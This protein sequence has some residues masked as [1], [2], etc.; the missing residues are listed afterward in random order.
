MMAEASPIHPGQ[1]LLPPVLPSRALL[2]VVVTTISYLPALT[3]F[4]H[5]DDFSIIYSSRDFRPTSLHLGADGAIRPFYRPLVFASMHLDRRLWGL[6]PAGF[7]LTNFMI[8]L[9]YVASVYLLAWWLPSIRTSTQTRRRFAALCACGFALHP[10]ATESVSWVAGR[11]GSQ[12]AFFAF[13]GAAAHAGLLRAGRAP[14]TPIAALAYPLAAGSKESVILFPFAVAAITVVIVRDEKLPARIAYHAYGSCL[15]WFGIAAG[16]LFLRSRLLGSA[17]GGYS[18]SH[19]ASV[20]LD[21]TELVLKLR[22]VARVFLPAIPDDSARRTAHSAALLLL[23]S[24]ALLRLQK[25]HQAPAARALPFW[26]PVF[27]FYLNLVPTRGLQIS[28]GSVQGERHLYLAAPFAVMAA[29][30]GW[31]SLQ[32]RFRIPSRASLAIAALWTISLLNTNIQWHRAGEIARSVIKDFSAI[33][34]T[35]EIAI[36]ALPDNLRGCHVLR[37]GLANGAFLFAGSAEE[38]YAKPVSLASL[39]SPADSLRITLSGSELRTDLLSVGGE[40]R[41]PRRGVAGESG[42]E[43]TIRAEGVRT[44][45]IRIEP[46]SRGPVYYYSDS[47][48][49]RLDPVTPESPRE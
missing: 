5:S 30:S 20:R 1:R 3:A 15:I 29:V 24:M 9:G 45:F 22:S 33:P 4:L 13:A 42:A 8:H 48:L 2:L 14:L 31:I 34:E 40:L 16:Y 11:T 7:H 28:M 38:R 44:H 46:A 26:L 18:G 37:N 12:A 23:S 47:R 19:L 6:R 32:E 10:A 35:G 17:F 43:I 39:T 25:H 27:L 49:M 41:I 21:P 36:I